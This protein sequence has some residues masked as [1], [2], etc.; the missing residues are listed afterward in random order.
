MNY[1]IYNFTEFQTLNILLRRQRGRVVSASDGG[2]G[3]ESRSDHY[4]QSGKTY[5]AAFC[6]SLALLAGSGNN[7]NCNGRCNRTNEVREVVVRL[8]IFFFFLLGQAWI[9]FR[10]FTVRKISRPLPAERLSCLY[11][12]WFAYKYAICKEG[13]LKICVFVP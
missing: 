1:F 9:F 11:I 5:C 7:A 10:H 8:D 6:A 12:L 13:L 3:F 4:L 2:P